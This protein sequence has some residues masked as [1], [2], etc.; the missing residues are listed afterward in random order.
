[1]VTNISQRDDAEALR[2][3]G[4]TTHSGASRGRHS[5]SKNL[6]IKGPNSDMPMLDTNK[7]KV[8]GVQNRI[9]AS[10]LK[11]KKFTHIISPK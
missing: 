7:F 9:P 11:L 2:K 8:P 5:R 3:S 1:M 10:P 6:K 4:L